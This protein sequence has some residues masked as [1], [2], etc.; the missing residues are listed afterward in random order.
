MKDDQR[1]GL[2]KRLKNIEDKNENQGIK[3]L[4]AIKSINMGSKPLK[5]IS[6]FRTISEEAKKL[7]V[8]NKQIDDWLD[9]A[10][11]VCTKTDGKTKYDFNKFVFPSKFTSK[12]YH[13]DLT[14][15]E[16]EN[17]QQELKIL[18][19]KLNNDCNQ[20]NQIKIGAKNDTL[21]SAK[22]SFNIRDKIIS[23][24]KKGVFPYIDGFQAQKNQM[25]N[26]MKNLRLKVKK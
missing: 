21:K 1:E 17:D 23:A 20:K 19:N 8:N 16:A 4:E 12:M 25:K 2:F 22:K 10:Q 7:M 15:Q 5:T 18:I 11:L 6:F 13:R 3:Q 26:Q 24:F 14:L 9:T